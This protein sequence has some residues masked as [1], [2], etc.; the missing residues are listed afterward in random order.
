MKL[1]IS[2]DQLGRFGRELLFLA[3]I[4]FMPIDSFSDEYDFV[5]SQ[6]PVL[7]S[8]TDFGSVAETTELMFSPLKRRNENSG[9]PKVRELYK[10]GK[11]IKWKF[12][13]GMIV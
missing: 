13:R 7:Q 3:L 10:D 5:K 4:Y 6:T 9:S 2:K 11:R 8:Q 1:E 12:V